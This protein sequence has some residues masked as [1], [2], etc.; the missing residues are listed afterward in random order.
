LL[1]A[2]K[3]IIWV[4]SGACIV[5]ALLLIAPKVQEASSVNQES[6]DAHDLDVHLTE[7]KKQLNEEQVKTLND[8]EQLIGKAEGESKLQLIDALAKLWDDLKNPPA[9]AIVL[10]RK[11]D[12][13]Y[14]EEIIRQVSEKYLFAS[15]F[16]DEHLKNEFLVKAAEGYEKVLQKNPNDINAKTDLAVC[17]VEGSQNPM[18]GIGL[19]K[20]VLE[21]DPENIKAHVNLGYFSI[22]SGQYEKAIERFEKVINI[23]PDYPEAYIY[24]GDVY[25]SLGNKQ[26]AIEYYSIYRDKVD[27]PML[28]QEISNYIAQLNQSIK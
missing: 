18:K 14:D 11:S 22:K 5:F 24:L 28:K 16:A 15:K 1:S 20:E 27:N 17:L 6:N 7:F 19:L 21:A 8:L 10:A 9:S 12:L 23:A 3:H 4:L 13:S 25:E 2:N 26:K